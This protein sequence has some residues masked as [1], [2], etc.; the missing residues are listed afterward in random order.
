[1]REIYGDPVR[2]EE[3]LPYFNFVG[4]DYRLSSGQTICQDFYANL[5]EAVDMAGK[6]AELW[7]RL[8]GKVDERRFQYVLDSLTRFA[9]TAR[10]QHDEM[11]KAFAGVT[12]R[13]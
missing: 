4:L 7:D 9:W 3:F 10:K 12:G 1:L 13:R 5:D 6:M 8:K 11:A 2:C